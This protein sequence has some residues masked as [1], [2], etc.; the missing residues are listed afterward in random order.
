MATRF[1]PVAAH[2]RTALGVKKMRELLRLTVASCA[3]FAVLGLVQERRA[4]AQEAPPTCA[5]LQDPIYVSGSSAIRPLLQTIGAKLAAA[6]TPSTIV[7]VSTGSC[8]GV[9]TIAGTLKVS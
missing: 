2:Q 3:A 8:D 9:N 6:T 7:Y 1:R 5:S 4:A